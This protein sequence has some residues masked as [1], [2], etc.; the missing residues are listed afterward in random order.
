MSRIILLNG[1]S[2]S[3]KTLIVKAIQH[4]SLTPWLT[5]GIDTLFK[6]MPADYVGFGMKAEQGIQFIP[7]KTDDDRPLMQIQTGPYGKQIVE[8]MPK[9]VKALADVGLDIILDE[10]LLRDEFEG[11][12]KCLENHLLYFIGV[13]CDLKNMEEREILREDRAWGLARDQIHKVHESREYDFRVD[14]T[15]ASPFEC[16]QMILD[17]IAAHPKK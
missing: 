10:V 8:A 5:L 14:T 15:H 1:C 17:Y 4:L 9:M 6:A 7:S 13:D 3:G 2:S 16:A 11:Y 12:R